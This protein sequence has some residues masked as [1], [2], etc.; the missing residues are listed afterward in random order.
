MIAFTRKVNLGQIKLSAFKTE[1]NGIMLLRKH[2]KWGSSL[3]GGLR[4]DHVWRFLTP[5]ISK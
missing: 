3:I 4:D 1:I 2:Y 5:V